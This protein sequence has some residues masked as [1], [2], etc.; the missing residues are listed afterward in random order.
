[1]SD[2]DFWNICKVLSFD[3]PMTPLAIFRF[4]R[5]T[6]R[7]EFVL[8]GNTQVLMRQFLDLKMGKEE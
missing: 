2:E 7:F 1:M 4:F 3:Y 8:Q 6:W 5:N